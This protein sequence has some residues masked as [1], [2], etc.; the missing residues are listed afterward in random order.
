MAVQPQNPFLYLPLE[1]REMHL[2]NLRQVDR[3]FCAVVSR[4][5]FATC[6]VNINDSTIIS[7]KDHGKKRKRGGKQKLKAIPFADFEIFRAKNNNIARNVRTLTIRCYGGPW[8]RLVGMRNYIK[9]YGKALMRICFAQF[10]R[11]RHLEIRTM[12]KYFDAEIEWD[13]R[14]LTKSLIEGLKDYMPPDLDEIGFLHQTIHSSPTPRVDLAP[15]IMARLRNFKSTFFTD[16][17]WLGPQQTNVFGLLRHGKRL[18]F[19]KI[20]GQYENITPRDALRPA[21][22]CPSIVHPDAPL[23]SFSLYM[24]TISASR[25]AGLRHFRNSLRYV[26]LRCVKLSTGCWDEVFQALSEMEGLTVLNLVYCGY[27]VNGSGKMFISHSD[28]DHRIRSTR[29]QDHLAMKE[30]IAATDRNYE[31]IG[32]EMAPWVVDPFTKDA[33]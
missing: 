27:D 12:N 7:P 15:S 21:P 4:E 31:A 19:V 28:E 25:L 20:E 17:H 32:E 5:M 6:T 2:R 10:V 33:G 1:I 14:C 3:S 22:L 13:A 8:D 18:I 9:P 16:K 29:A 24:V 30:C 26:S 11:L 23:R